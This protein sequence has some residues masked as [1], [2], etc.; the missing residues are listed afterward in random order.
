MSNNER[1]ISKKKGSQLH[2]VQSMDAI[3][4]LVKSQAIR[5]SDFRKIQCGEY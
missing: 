1:Q 4:P 5:F 3:M 2:G